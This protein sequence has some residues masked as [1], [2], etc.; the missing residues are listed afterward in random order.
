MLLAIEDFVPVV[1]SALGLWFVSRT[2]RSQNGPLGKPAL[3]GTAMVAL[4]GLAKATHKL[5]LAADGRDIAFLDAALFP[6]LAAGFAVVTA[7][8][9]STRRPDPSVVAAMV[10]AP[11]VWLIGFGLYGATGRGAFI[12]LATLSSVTLSVLLVRWAQRMRDK[13]AAAL[14][15]LSLVLTV[16]LGGMA[17]TLG[18]AAEF[19]W[20]EQGTNTVAQAVFLLAAIRLYRA[21]ADAT[22][23]RSVER[24]IQA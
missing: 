10:A 4:G 21:T 13:L 1:L 11:A 8:V 9:W 5:V 18:D 22:P 2:V 14:F 3:V 16:V 19:Q 6:L 17:P 20:I 24:T 7:S 15:A 12:G 23:S